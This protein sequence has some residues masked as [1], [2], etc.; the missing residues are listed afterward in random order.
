MRQKKTKKAF[1]LLELSIVIMIISIL[2]TGAL[3]VS[4]T[5]VN[6]AKIKVTKD[7]IAEVYKALGNFLLVNGRLP[8]PASLLLTKSSSS[9]GSE[10]GTAGT[11]AASGT[12]TYSSSTSTSLIIGMVPIRSLGLPNEM[13]EDGFENKL[14]YVV[15]KGFTSST[16]FGTSG[17]TISGTTITYNSV[18]TVQ[19][20][21]LSNAQTATT[22]A[23][24][25]LMSY[26]ANEYGSFGAN[27]SSQNSIPSPADS[28]EQSN[29]IASIS[30]TTANFDGTFMASSGS[31]EVFDDIVFYKTRN[32]LVQDFSAFSTI[33]CAAVSTSD[34]GTTISW[35][36]GSYDQN[37]VASTS[38][39]TGYQQGPV[40][41]TKKCNAFGIWGV[42]TSPCLS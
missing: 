36:Q 37:V 11:C 41:P 38:C 33:P 18:I 23:I 32:Q 21:P 40:K 12:G 28:D 6:N 31:S 13:G 4:V 2:I 17:V 20:K 14:V 26:G 34:Y 7:R 3:S 10:A 39:P 24:F 9:Y 22:N 16:T 30:G 8:C 29:W 35:P 27:S 15:D 25:L 1:S 19:E 42:V 5:S